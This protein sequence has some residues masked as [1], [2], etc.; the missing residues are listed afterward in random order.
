MLVDYFWPFFTLNVRFSCLISYHKGRAKVK[1]NTSGSNFEI[2]MKKKRFLKK[3]NYW[4]SSLGYK[5]TD[6][7]ME[8]QDQYLKRLAGLQRLYSAVLISKLRRSQANQLHPHCLENGWIW[9]SNFLMLDPLPGIS[10]TLLVEFFQIAGASMLQC[11]RGQL[12]KLMAVLFLDYMPKL[13]QV[14]HI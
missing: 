8:D 9:L 12:M 10:P 14:I 3:K 13:N 6:G 1:M 11:Y 4:N 7:K 2:S 5:F